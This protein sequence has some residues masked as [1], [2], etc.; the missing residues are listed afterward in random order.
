MLTDI[1]FKWRM[2]TV[3]IRLCDYCGYIRDEERER[4]GKRCT[5]V[6]VF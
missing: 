1:I 4:D 6:Q 5:G 2:D 3:L